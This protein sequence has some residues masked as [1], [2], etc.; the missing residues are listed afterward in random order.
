MTR[1]DPTSDLADLCFAVATRV[2]ECVEDGR[3]IGF[4]FIDVV[5]YGP[6]R[7]AL[8]A[9]I[10]ALRDR[11][12]AQKNPEPFPPRSIDSLAYTVINLLR[13]VPPPSAA[14]QKEDR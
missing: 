11:L 8:F 12:A 9:R 7:D 1:S 6:D 2:L 3:L 10:R 5:G 4:D 13:A 14:P